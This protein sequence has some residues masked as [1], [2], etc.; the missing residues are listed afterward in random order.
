MTSPE[1]SALV[2]IFFEGSR[3]KICFRGIR[4]KRLILIFC[5]CEMKLESS[6]DCCL[7]NLSDT[8]LES[9]DLSILFHDLK[10][11]GSL[12][13]LILAGTKFDR[14]GAKAVSEY[15]KLTS[16]L[17]RLDLSRSHLSTDVCQLLA[18]GMSQNTSLATLVIRDAMITREGKE[19]LRKTRTEAELLID[20]L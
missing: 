7:L 5:C 2:N 1:F 4:I 13:E 9:S 10:L 8:H 17:Q 20:G 6:P 3:T 15:L 12:R 11:C 16:S 14:T 19:L 18:C